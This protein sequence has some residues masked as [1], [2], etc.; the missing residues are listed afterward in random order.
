MFSFDR[1]MCKVMIADLQ[2]RYPG[3]GTADK[4]L[5]YTNLLHPGLKGGVLYQMGK[6]NGIIEQ[7]INE[8]EGAPEA[9][10]LDDAIAID[11][12][13]EEQRMIL[14]ST[15]A[16]MIAPTTNESPLTTE[17][18]QYRKLPILPMTV[19]I[20]AF[21]RD[22]QRTFPMLAKIVKRYFCIQS[23]SCSSERTFS[24]GEDTVT[25]KRNR[26]DPNNVHML[27]YLRENLKKVKLDRL[28][29]EDPIE[30][31]EEKLILEELENDDNDKDD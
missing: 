17:I 21:W 26:L 14:E 18:N 23:T 16:M 5:A 31:A 19:D 9:A 12:D 6:Y 22:N 7:L 8:E 27:V 15:Q 1:D 20:L 24:I 10:G 29:V 30:E 2:T 13:D 25:A 3:Y 28:I 11:S 4:L